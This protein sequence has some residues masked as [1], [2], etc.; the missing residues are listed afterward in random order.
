MAEASYFKI[1]TPLGFAKAHK[2]IQ[3]NK[4]AWP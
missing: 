3:K 2:K 4:W 1:G